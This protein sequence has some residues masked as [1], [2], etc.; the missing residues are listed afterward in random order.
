MVEPSARATTPT[1]KRGTTLIVRADTSVTIATGHVMRCLALAQAWQDAGGDAVFAL[2]ETTTGVQE[3]LASEGIQCVQIGQAPG[4][5]QDA[6]AT[7][8]LARSRAATWVVVDGDRFSA[9]FLLSLRSPDFRTLLVDDFA[10]RTSYPVDLILNT[11]PGASPDSYPGVGTERLLIGTRYLL[12]RREFTSC[13][14][15]RNFPDVAKRI[16]V[17]LGGTDPDNLAPRIVQALDRSL[18]QDVQLTV[19]AG[20]GYPK[21]QELQH[22]RSARVRIL[23]NPSNM[24]QI[25][26]ATDLAII[27]A[28]GT[29]WELLYMG[30]AVLSYA[31]NPVQARVVAALEGSGVVY[32]LGDPQFFDERSL[33]EPVERIAGSK[34]RRQEMATKGQGLID[35]GGA[36]RVLQAMVLRAR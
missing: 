23:V 4:S 31:R 30:C 2:A 21:L 6:E 22:V 32:N 36:H 25:I 26:A 35:G 20:A 19:V 15:D 14:R 1:L 13:E 18:A 9:D 28:G 16:L 29:L 11:N 27:A 34:V 8:T 17:T 3:R 12:L 7:A 10:E 24:P 33:I 5:A